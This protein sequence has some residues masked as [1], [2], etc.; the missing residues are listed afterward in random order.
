MCHA[1]WKIQ[2]YVLHHM[3]EL[4][5]GCVAMHGLAYGQALCLWAVSQDHMLL[6]LMYCVCVH[7]SV[8]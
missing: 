7:E 5:L 1:W 4:G 3:L 6:H 2:L 8:C